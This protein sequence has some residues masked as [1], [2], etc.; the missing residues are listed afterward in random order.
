MKARFSLSFPYM[1]CLHFE[2]GIFSHLDGE[3]MTWSLSSKSLIGLNFLTTYVNFHYQSVPGKKLKLLSTFYIQITPK[4]CHV[5]LPKLCPSC[6]DL[7]HHYPSQSLV[8][9]LHHL[10]SGTLK[11]PPCQLPAIIA[12]PG[13]S[14]PSHNYEW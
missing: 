12:F 5:F 2:T 9:G 13:W 6:L 8:P 7:C 1:V 10:P 3:A 4:T 11:T 14:S